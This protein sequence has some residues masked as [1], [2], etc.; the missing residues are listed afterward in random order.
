M[1]INDLTGYKKDSDFDIIQWKSNT[2]PATD[3]IVLR[4]TAAESVRSGTTDF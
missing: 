2:D 1:G 3:F 4:L